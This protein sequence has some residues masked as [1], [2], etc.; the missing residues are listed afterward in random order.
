MRK[1]HYHG[2]DIYSTPKG[3]Y[4]SSINAAT[5]DYVIL[6]RKLHELVDL[7]KLGVSNIVCIKDSANIDSFLKWQLTR[8]RAI[9]FVIGE[10][11]RDIL[12]DK[13]I[14]DYNLISYEGNR[15]G[16]HAYVK[17]L[18]DLTIRNLS[19]DRER[20]AKRKANQQDCNWD[21]EDSDLEESE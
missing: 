2:L 11:A 13:E 8:N 15:I 1:L 18:I 5:G 9:I 6:C 21:I 19:L 7:I 4:W 17:E 10:H 14:E 16:G 3:S 12:A 20:K